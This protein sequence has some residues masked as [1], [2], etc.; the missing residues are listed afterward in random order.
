MAVHTK[1]KRHLR[2]DKKNT[3]R[4]KRI[5]NTLKQ[6]KK[7]MRGGVFEEDLYGISLDLDKIKKH[8][9]VIINNTG[10]TLRIKEGEKKHTLPEDFQAS[11]ENLQTLLTDLETLPEDLEPLPEDLE[12][13]PKS[14]T[15]YA[16]GISAKDGSFYINVTPEDFTKLTKD[17]A[18]NIKYWKNNRDI[19]LYDRL[20]AIT[21]VIAYGYTVKGLKQLASLNPIYDRSIVMTT[22]KGVA[23][24][25]SLGNRGNFGHGI[26]PLLD[27]LSAVYTGARKKLT[28]LGARKKLTALY[29]EKN[30]EEQQ[31]LKTNTSR[32]TYV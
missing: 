14:I 11:E 1:V 28:A 31:L 26:K 6:T 13:L 29:T 8:Y 10:I 7:I 30:E 27:I 4:R 2:N 9:N 24:F 22:S 18:E 5:N 32:T 3:R 19:K 12:T 25:I 15:A 20:G 17:N 23:N 21:P 16:Y